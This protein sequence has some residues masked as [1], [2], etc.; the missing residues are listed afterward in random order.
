MEE[1]VRDQHEECEQQFAKVL[2]LSWANHAPSDRGKLQ[3][4][5]ESLLLHPGLLWI[6]ASAVRLETNCFT[7]KFT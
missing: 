3:T 4:H 1:G 6:C 7:F 5:R 2:R